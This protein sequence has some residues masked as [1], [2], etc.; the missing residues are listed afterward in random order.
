MPPAQRTKVRAV[1]TGSN[2]TTTG[3]TN[4][5]E[6]STAAPIAAQPQSPNS[7][8][9]PA[10]APTHH[11]ILIDASNAGNGTG[12]GITNSTININLNQARRD[13][14][15][16]LQLGD[17]S[18]LVD[19][20]HVED[21]T[22]HVNILPVRALDKSVG[23]HSILIDSSSG[24]ESGTTSAG[25]HSGVVDTSSGSSSDNSSSTGIRS[26]T[27]NMTVVA[28]KV[29]ATDD[30]DEEEL[31]APKLIRR[32][33]S[34]PAWAAAI[35]HRSFDTST[36]ESSAIP[37]PPSSAIV[38]PSSEQSSPVEEL[39]RQEVRRSHASRPSRFSRKA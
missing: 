36:E 16:K 23:K 26:S 32:S 15:R 20:E 3:P 9:L 11:N 33:E 1:R 31:S 21:S 30:N 35:K 27:I 13:R 19:T 14:R 6:P 37:P 10:D 2:S 17:H 7:T 5:T 18:I 34:S 25:D 28:P 39:V 29:S 22:V 4:S 24:N 38:E 8:T 12:G